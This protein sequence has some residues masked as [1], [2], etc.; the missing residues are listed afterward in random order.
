MV[1]LVM[2]I[3]FDSLNKNPVMKL[4][5]GTEALIQVELLCPSPASEACTHEIA[6]A[7]RRADALRHRCDLGCLSVLSTVRLRMY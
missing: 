2:V 4:W 3:Y 7:I 5:D 1:F 6:E